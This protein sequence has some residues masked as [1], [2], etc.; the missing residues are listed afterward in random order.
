MNVLPGSVKTLNVFTEACDGLDLDV[1]SIIC[2]SHD[3]PFDLSTRVLGRRSWYTDEMQCERRLAAF[4]PMP[5]FWMTFNFN[6]E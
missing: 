2:L 5:S 6:T 3:V 4:M 1:C